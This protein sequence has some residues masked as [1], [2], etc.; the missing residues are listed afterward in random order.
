[1][2]PSE[3]AQNNINP[4]SFQ[5][6][7]GF[8]IAFLFVL[9]LISV[10]SAGL[11]TNMRKAIQGVL[12]AAAVAAIL[13]AAALPQERA[14]SR[15]RI[16]VESYRLRNGLRVVLSQDQSLPLV[17]VVVAYGAGSIREQPGQVGLA[18]LM[19]NMMFQ[20]SE[21]V[22]PLQHINFIQKVG[23]ELN[24]NT[25][26]DKALFY[27]T[28]PS[29]QLGLALWLE[30]DRMKSLL[31]TSAGVQK[32]EQELFT[33][34][35][36]RLAAEP[37]LESYSVFDTLL[38][39]DFPYG[40]PLIDGS[41]AIAVLPAEAVQA[42][43]A[44]YYVPNNAVL[45][46]VGNIQVARTKELVAKYFESIPPGS[47]VPSPPLPHFD[48]RQEVVQT[49]KGIPAAYPG[50]HIGYRFYPLQTGDSYSLRILEYV[51]LRGQTS[52]LYARLMK[53]DLTAQYMNGSLEDRHG[54]AALKIF[55]LNV[56]EVLAERCQKSLISEIEKLK[57][58]LVSE[59]ELNRARNFFKMDYYEKMSNGLDRALYLV[60][61]AV[62]DIP[63]DALSD[64]LGKY[65]RV[66]PQSLYSLANRFFNPQN[67]V[68]LN[69]GT[70]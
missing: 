16:Q 65:M 61:A 33:E 64:E 19:E 31:L 35:Q 63:L 1:M 53:K 32:K 49:M 4:R 9:L 51:L 66:S 11:K 29:N 57:V 59:D 7:G 28:L 50:F 12:A 10:R 56:N 30:S 23:G 46:I 25:T 27:E 34:Y 8:D 3:R 60:D 36:R 55:V 42:F 24:A 5:S 43:H 15:W 44:E 37:Y 18:Y 21:N 67:M 41:E 62:S 20:G 45:A 58:N 48:Q 38:Y 69:L 6:G 70:R 68:I 52:R 47:D 40:H 17:S 14:P 22:S 39:P 54:V 2:D 26:V 13:A